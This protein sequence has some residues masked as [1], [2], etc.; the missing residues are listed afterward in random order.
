VI[1]ADGEDLAVKAGPEWVGLGGLG[2]CA[3]MDRCGVG[4]VLAGLCLCC[5]CFSDVAAGLPRWFLI[6]VFCD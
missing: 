5:V 6:F 3:H 2:G 4:R 1:W